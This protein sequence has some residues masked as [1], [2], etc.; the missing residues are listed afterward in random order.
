MTT[1]SDCVFAWMR[2]EFAGLLGICEQDIR[3]ETPLA[4]FLPKE[5]RRA[6]WRLGQSQLGLRFPTLQLAPGMERTGNWLTIGSFA[7]AVLYGLLIGP[8]WLVPP[9]ILLAS[10]GTPILF[11][12]VSLPWQTEHPD[13]ETFGDLS[14]LLLARNMKKFR[15]EFGLRPNHDEIYSTIRALL[16][17]NGVAPAAITPDVSFAELCDC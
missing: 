8:K 15:G 10:F 17:E 13:L 9:L 16:I 2:R 5:R 14:R 3:P 12:F 6:F 11:H 7:R 1:L 4:R